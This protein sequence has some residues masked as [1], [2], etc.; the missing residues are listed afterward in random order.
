MNEEQDEQ[1]VEKITTR[2]FNLGAID[3][4]TRVREKY[5]RRKT[6]IVRFTER[7]ERSEGWVDEAEIESLR[8][9]GVSE[10]EIKG[11]LVRYG[12]V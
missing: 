6:A 10:D 1:T 8:A 9:V 11:L 3:P 5:A 7:L 2:Y 4:A 12:R